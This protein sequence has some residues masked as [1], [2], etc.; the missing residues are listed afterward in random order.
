MPTL[1]AVFAHPDDETF[2]PGGTLAKYASSGVEVHYACATKGEAGEA[3]AELLQNHPDVASL[4]ATELECASRILGIKEVHFLGYRDSGMSG[5]EDNLHPQSLEQAP[6]P[7]VVGKI[8]ALIRQIRPQVLITFDPHGGYGHPD[9][10]KIHRT[11]T[12][13]FYAA[14]DPERFPEQRE[15]GLSRH[16]TGCLYYTAF[17]RRALR[18]WIF[19]LPLLGKDPSR[20]GANQDID[21]RKIAEWSQKITA[22][23]E[24]RRFLPKKLEAAACHRSQTAPMRDFPLPNWLRAWLMGVENFTRVHPPAEGRFKVERDLFAG[25]RP[26]EDPFP[27]RPKAEAERR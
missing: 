2:G 24:V 9:H 17:P 8:V 23:I 26:Q 14:S 10:I 25:I 6:E 7:E 3:P 11:A 4:R 15:Q 1:L 22:R 13:A 12:E 5:S 27:G 20:W 21:L 18:F 19:T 16:R